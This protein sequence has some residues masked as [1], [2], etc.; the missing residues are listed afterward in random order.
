MSD[1]S[2]ADPFDEEYFRQH[3]FNTE[4]VAAVRTALEEA[5][6]QGRDEVDAQLLLVGLMGNPESVAGAMVRALG[7]TLDRVQHAARSLAGGP[8]ADAGSPPSARVQVRIGDQAKQVFRLAVDEAVRVPSNPRYV[9][10][11]H[12]LLGVIRVDPDPLSSVLRSA[13]I[14]LERAR[15]ARNSALG[16][17]P[18]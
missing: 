7:E 14:T 4:A 10:S 18:S 9:G 12:L 3:L 8:H 17:P 2:D 13:G 5:A 16:L 11:E 6:R 1:F 15:R